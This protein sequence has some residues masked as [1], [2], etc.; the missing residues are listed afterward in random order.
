[1]KVVKPS[2]IISILFLLSPI[3]NCENVDKTKL[4]EYLQKEGLPPVEYVISKFQNHDI[5]LLGEIHRVKHQVEFVSDLIP[6]LYKNG[7]Y[8]LAIEFANSSQQSLIQDVIHSKILLNDKLFA[9]FRNSTS[10][11][12]YKQ[13]VDLVRKCWEFNNNLPDDARKFRVIGLDLD[14]DYEKKYYGT[15]AEQDSLKDAAY[16]RDEHMFKILKKEVLDKN[17]KVLVYTGNMHAIT[18]LIP[19]KVTDGKVSKTEKRV[20]LGNY[21]YQEYQDKLFSIYFY[22]PFISLTDLKQNNFGLIAPFDGQLEEVF[23]SNNNIKVG[24]DISGSSPF[25]NLKCD[26]AVYEIM[27]SDWSFGDLADGYIFM[28][29]IQDWQPIDVEDIYITETNFLEV[30]KKLPNRDKYE[31]KVQIL[32]SQVKEVNKIINWIKSSCA[33]NH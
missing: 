9:V 14:I 24:F 5:V 10:Y 22:A 3:A 7:V 23:N 33:L 1:M 6:H 26:S 25:S 17:E 21:L 29:P 31:R 28:Y 8:N 19:P 20:R 27:K 32:N 4:V 18:K 12:C 2:L 13:Y 30:L 11:W 15:P 16:L